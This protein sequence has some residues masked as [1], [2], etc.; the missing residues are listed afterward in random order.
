MDRFARRVYTVAGIYGLIV[1]LPQYFLEDRIGRDTPPPI[2]H[3]EYFYGFIG[4]V[5]AWQLA[6]LVIGR[7]PQRYRALMPVTVLEKL[8]F[9]V[10]VL[11]LWSKGH[12]P[13]SV[14][15]FAGLD[16]ILGALFLASYLRAKSA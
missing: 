16:L 12:V 9:A 4:V 7:D 11:L 3:T 8:V 13:P 6:F 14:L 1:M 10:P 2:T 15:P 5:L